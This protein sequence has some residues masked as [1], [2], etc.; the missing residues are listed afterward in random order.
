MKHKL[1]IL[2]Y[3]RVLILTENLCYQR[4]TKIWYILLKLNFLTVT[5]DVSFSVEKRMLI[6]HKYIYLISNKMRKHDGTSI[7][8]KQMYLLWGK[9]I[10]VQADMS[11]AAKRN[12]KRVS[13][14]ID[15]KFTWKK[16]FDLENMVWGQNT[17]VEWR[18]KNH[19]RGSR[20]RKN[21]MKEKGVGRSITLWRWKEERIR[22]VGRRNMRKEGGRGVRRITCWRGRRRR[23]NRLEK[24]GGGRKKARGREKVRWSGRSRKKGMIEEEGGR[25]IW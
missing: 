5:L 13:I 23:R 15:F 19:G 12:A 7:F 10:F 17:L 4:K 1:D 9:N 20:S 6:A 3:C 11:R 2:K 8:K 16:Y 14:K 18:R 25:I 22:R 24:G 21:M